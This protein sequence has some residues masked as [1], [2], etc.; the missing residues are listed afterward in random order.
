MF[1]DR[2]EPV[3][4]YQYNSTGGYPLQ[5]HHFSGSAAT[6]GS[7]IPARNSS[8]APPPVEICEIRSAT[9]A[10]LIAFSESPPPT[11]LTAPDHATAFAS[12]TVPRS[13]GGTSN[14]PI[15]PLQP[16]VPAAPTEFSSPTI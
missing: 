3:N 2:C 5:P 10:D 4:L 9:P 15:A 12:A 6:P 7:S 14:T 16:L 1:L 8:D 13:N 11:T